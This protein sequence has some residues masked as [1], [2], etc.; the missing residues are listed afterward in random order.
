[1]TPNPSGNPRKMNL[2]DSIALA[3]EQVEKG[4]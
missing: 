2:K 3:M 4:R 1:L